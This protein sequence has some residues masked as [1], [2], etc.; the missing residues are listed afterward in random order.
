MFRSLLRRRRREAQWH[1]HV[2]T[3]PGAERHEITTTMRVP[4]DL[5]LHIGA[6]E[7]N[8]TLMTSLGGWPHLAVTGSDVGVRVAAGSRSWPVVALVNDVNGTTIL[9][10][11]ERSRLRRPLSHDGELVP[12]TRLDRSTVSGGHHHHSGHVPDHGQ[13]L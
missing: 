4:S 5:G 7:G 3:G 2:T 13:A 10:E 11:L 1:G 12:L 6:G 8:R 9:V